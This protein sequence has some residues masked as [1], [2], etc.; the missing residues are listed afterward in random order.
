MDGDRPG[1]AGLPRRPHYVRTGGGAP[2]PSRF[3]RVLALLVGRFHADRRAGGG[4]DA[5]A[6]PTGVHPFTGFNANGREHSGGA[7]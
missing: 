1:P 3:R 7:G 2:A 4:A 6:D 5:G